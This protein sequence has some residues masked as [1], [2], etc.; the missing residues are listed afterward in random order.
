MQAVITGL[1]YSPLKG[2]TIAPTFRMIISEDEEMENSVVVNFQF[3][4]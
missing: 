2:L 4:F 1:H 3:K